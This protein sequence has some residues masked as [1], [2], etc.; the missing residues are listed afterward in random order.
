VIIY[1]L[2]PVGKDV[3]IRANADD[4]SLQCDLCE[5]KY[6]VPEHEDVWTVAMIA[7][8]HWRQNH[9]KSANGARFQTASIH[10]VLPSSM[11]G[12]VCLC[13][14]DLPKHRD[15]TEHIIDAYDAAL[16]KLKEER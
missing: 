7:L 15:A 10:Q 2:L 1:R 16:R 8:H 9:D 13:G 6:I 12:L 11:G 3:L 4:K 14:V 5:W